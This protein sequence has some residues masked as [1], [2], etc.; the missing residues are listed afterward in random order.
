MIVSDAGGIEL[1]L[2]ATLEYNPSEDD[3]THI[4]E[5]GD[6]LHGLAAGYYN[7]MPNPATLWWV[8]ADYQP[9]PIIDPTVVL[10]PGDLIIIPS[11]SAV[12]G[13]LFGLLEDE[14]VLV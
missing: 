10:T 9:V 2:R 3:I 4:V 13:A 5:A 1:D 7:G 12:Q 11:P 8:I 6:T 14:S